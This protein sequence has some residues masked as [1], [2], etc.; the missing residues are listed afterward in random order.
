[1]SLAL[2][3]IFMFVGFGLTTLFRKW[4]DIPTLLAVAIGCACNANL[5]TAITHPISAGPFI[6]SFEIVLYTLFIYTIVVRILDYGNKAA[7][8]MTFTSIA[9]IIIS[10]FIELVVSLSI[11]GFTADVFKRFSYYI[12]SSIG[13]ILG[14]WLMIVITINLKK[15][16]VS[17]YIIIPISLVACSVVHSVIYYGGYALVNISSGFEFY[18]WNAVLGTVIGKA[19]CIGLSLIYY[20]INKTVWIPNTLIKMKKDQEREQ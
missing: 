5:F 7:K 18:P 4:I 3:I 11:I 12:F 10:A 8:V 13:T 19:V 20:L 2:L 1:M 6:F 9:A 17:S 14:V 15:K 16:S